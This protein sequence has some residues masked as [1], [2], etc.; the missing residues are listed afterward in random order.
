MTSYELVKRS[1]HFDGPA[2][3]P[4]TG[5]MSETDFR[6]DTVALFPEFPMKWWLG[7]GGTDEWGCQW[8]VSPGS[9][10]MGQVKNIILENL[11]DYQQLPIPNVEIPVRYAGWANSITRA[12]AEQKYIVVCNGTCIFERAH[13]IHGFE[14]T[15]MNS[16]LEPD[17]M[18]EFLLHLAQYHLRSIEYIKQHFP[19]RVHGYRVTDDWGTQQAPLMPPETFRAVFK[20]V[21]QEIFDVAH[22]AGMDVWLHSCG[23]ILPLMDDLID[24][25]VN[26]LNLMQPNVFPIPALREFRGRVCFEVCADAQ[27]TL[28]TGTPDALKEEV[29]AILDNC[30][31]KNGGIIEVKLDRMYFDG[32]GVS[33]EYGELCHAEYRKRD[34]FTAG[35]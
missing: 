14:N 20:P 23:Q 33:K 28:L 30:C 32:D 25:G 26:V 12:E 21:Y 22:A 16:M 1:I 9:N 2:R 5:S 11:A 6:G 17:L 27:N 7:G 15:L 29:Q 10:D 24:C 35:V 13:F 3:L 31:A 34:P 18:T 19:G 4:F 8:E